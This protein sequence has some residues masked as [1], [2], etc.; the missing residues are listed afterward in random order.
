MFHR[1][2][3]MNSL[4][5]IYNQYFHNLFGNKNLQK[6]RISEYNFESSILTVQVVNT[7]TF[8][9]ITV[10]DIFD[11]GYV[12][13]FNN[14]DLMCLF[15][16][17]GKT[18]QKKLINIKGINYSNS[19]T[20]YNIYDFDKKK[21]INLSALELHMREDFLSLDKKD[22]SMVSFNAGI[23]YEQKRQTIK[24]MI[25]NSKK[26]KL[27]NSIFE[28]NDIKFTVANNDL[29]NIMIISSN[30]IEEYIENFDSKD[31]FLLGKCIQKIK[32][33]N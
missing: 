22:I 25:E 16:I 23:E 18:D 30:D 13:L 29:D 12:V 8:F 11:K 21:F 14:T 4:K 3:N 10:Q 7:S 1:A 19:K 9:N 24:K 26:I 20:E 27:I 17:F 32:Q 2:I 28:N 5:T 31:S 15:Y 33:M 6:L